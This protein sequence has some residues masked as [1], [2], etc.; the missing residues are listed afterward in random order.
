M[1]IRMVRIAAGVYVGM[2]ALMAIRQRQY[3]YH[4][5]RLTPDEADRLAAY[6]GFERWHD[7]TGAFAGWR[8]PRKQTESHPP[9]KRV[10]LFHG[11]AGHALH[12]THYALNLEGATGHWDVILFA[13]PGFGL[14]DGKPSEA[15]IV[16]AAETALQTLMAESS[17]PVYLIGESLGSGPACALAGRY[18]EAI[19]GLWLV[20]P[21]S[22]LVD[23]ARTHYPILPVRFMLRDRFD[24]VQALKSFPGRLFV[25]AAAH[26][27]VVPSKLARRLYESAP[28][29]LK[30]W[31]LQ[32]HADHNT[33][34]LSPTAGVWE[35]VASFWLQSN[36]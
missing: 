19:A 6:E 25:L 32:P 11:N 14:R 35:A 15:A 13:Y 20:T 24:N 36:G 5:Q 28:T 8:R 33:L 7:H 23:A 17:H 4:P 12:R 34:D 30:Q 18:P 26:D 16:S 10:L 3:I 1:I 2:T 31:M 21:F 27:R 9:S 22:S 29:P